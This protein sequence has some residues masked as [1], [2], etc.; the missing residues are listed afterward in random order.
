M[1]RILRHFLLFMGQDIVD[2]EGWSVSAT[3]ILRG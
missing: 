2:D 1:T 3:G